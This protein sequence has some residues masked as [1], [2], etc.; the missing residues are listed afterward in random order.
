[1]PPGLS[2]EPRGGCRGIISDID[3]C[4]NVRVVKPYRYWSDIVPRAGIVAPAYAIPAPTSFG[5]ALL[6]VRN[7]LLVA[8]TLALAV[9]IWRRNTP[10][11]IEPPRAAG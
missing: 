1:M 3:R 4:S 7:G 5:V 9:L 8:L 10:D 2:K 6:A 11:R